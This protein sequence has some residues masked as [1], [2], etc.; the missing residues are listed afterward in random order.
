MSERNVYGFLPLFSNKVNQDQSLSGPSLQVEQLYLCGRLP[1]SYQSSMCPSL[2][3][4]IIP[5]DVSYFSEIIF[6]SME[7]SGPRWY[8]HDREVRTQGLRPGLY[9]WIL[10][11]PNDILDL[12]P[13]AGFPIRLR[14][15]NTWR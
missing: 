5:S 7:L 12:G 11:G 10:F 8:T 15:L 3:L 9:P 1:F 6:N 2:L 13:K 14:D 4:T